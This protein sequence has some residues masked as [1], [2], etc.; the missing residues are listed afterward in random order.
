MK[1]VFIKKIAYMTWTLDLVT[2]TLSQLQHLS[3][4]NHVCKYHPYPDIGS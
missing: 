3:D 4:T 2:L 1:Q